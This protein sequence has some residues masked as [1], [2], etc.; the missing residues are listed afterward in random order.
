MLPA[1][2]TRRV[3]TIPEVSKSGKRIN[4]LFRLME[5]PDLWMQAYQKIH[6]NTGATTPGVDRNTLDGFSEE[7]VFNLIEL[8]TTDR[9]RPK[10]VRRTYRPKGDGRYRPLGVPT[11]DDKLVQEVI[12]GLLEHIYEPIFSDRSHGFRPK[13]SCH[14]ALHEIDDRWTG[15]KWFVEADIEGFYDN[16]DHT[17]LLRA[18]G[19][20]IEDPRF[21]RLIERFLQAGYMEDWRWNPTYSG[22]PQGGIVSPLLSNVYLHAFDLFMEEMVRAFTRGTKRKDF[23]PY[24]TISTRCRRLRKRVHAA[25]EQGDDTTARKWKQEILHQEKLR[26][27]YPAGDPYDPT[28][29]RLYYCRYADDFVLGVIG[30]KAEAHDILHQVEQ[31][32]HQHLRLHVARQ[33]TGVK[34]A[35]EGVRFLGYDLRAYTSECRR[36][37][38]KQGIY[39]R[40]RIVREQLQLHIPQEKLSAFARQHGYGNLDLGVAS[41]RGALLR[42]DEPTIIHVYNAE[43]RGFANYYSLATSVKRRLSKLYWLWWQSLYKTLAGKHQT[44]VRKMVRTMK[45][46][47]QYIWRCTGRNG[48]PKHFAIQRFGDLLKQKAPGGAE[49]DVQPNTIVLRAA[50]TKLIDR[51]TAN[52]CEYCGKHGGYFEVHHIR[53]MKDLTGKQAWEKHMIALRRKTI[54]LCIQCHHLLHAG[55]LPDMR[56]KDMQK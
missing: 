24:H 18:L 20:K 14:T 15:V 32:L 36:K 34:H 7:R 39:T 56:R 10:P 48:Q 3:E 25:L 21:L 53:K 44:S 28:F 38:K 35:R 49:V 50:R 5:T 46:G 54:V 17:I 1:T 9:Y 47:K 27:H 12:R 42:N 26:A 23:T 51:L 30:S 19:E 31:F 22:A 43:L 52:A 29:R 55:T 13:R 4:G 6:T 40:Q 8:L 41:H 11:G 33:K 2:V 16:F 45:S 37:F